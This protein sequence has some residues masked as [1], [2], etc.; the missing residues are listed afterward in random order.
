MSDERL[1]SNEYNAWS[2]EHL[3]RYIVAKGYINSNDVVL[4]IASGTGYGTC[5]L[6]MQTKNAVIGGDISEEAVAGCK[7]R[8]GPANPHVDFRVMDGTRL[9][10]PD[11]YFDK[12]VSFETIEHTA[13]YREMLGEFKRVLKPA[14]TLVLSTPNQQITSPDGIIHNPY[15]VQEFSLEQL[16]DMLSSL[17]PEIKMYGQRN[18]RFDK[19]GFRQSWQKLVT[20][21]WNIRGIRKS[22]FKIKNKI[23]AIFA[24]IQLFPQP[25][26][27][28]L[29]KD[30]EKIQLKCPVLLAVCKKSS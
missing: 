24:G 19:K 22:P 3:H 9:P 4:D 16:Q 11:N 2:G 25:E 15:H 26:D 14:G 13:Q 20:G 27:F 28:I 8:W 30:S 21:F 12:I 1:V 7:K 23:T 6:G 18:A 5:Q 17:F 10:F 29:E